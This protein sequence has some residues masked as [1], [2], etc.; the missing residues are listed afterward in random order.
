[1]PES[2]GVPGAL[3]AKSHSA[4][5]VNNA[6]PKKMPSVRSADMRRSESLNFA[7]ERAESVV[8]A[9]L[10]EAVL[11]EHGLLS[12][13]HSRPSA[14]A[15]EFFTKA[16]YSVDNQI[17]FITK[18]L[19]TSEGRDKGFKFM[20]YWCQFLAW[21]TLG[22][23]KLWPGSKD[24]ISK[25][26]EKIR[27]STSTARKFFKLFNFLT[28]IQLAIKICV[29]EKD[30][31]KKGLVFVRFIGLAGYFWFDH[32]NWASKVGIANG[33]PR[34]LAKTG[35]TCLLVSL[36]STF[37]LDYMT[38]SSLQAEERAL[39]LDREAD[40]EI[41]GTLDKTEEAFY[42]DRQKALFT[43]KKAM[44][45]QA[46]KNSLDAF[47]ASDMVFSLKMVPG[48]VALANALSATIGVR[49][50]YKRLV[51]ETKAEQA[52]KKDK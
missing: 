8:S 45:V 7:R 28:F 17:S 38:F 50:Y 1:M 15:A 11:P 36:S 30:I 41:D 44:A 26:F 49:L 3:G 43:K 20:Q 24:V 12:V 37:C 35:L 4:E 14:V 21:Y 27:S 51:K 9:A 16:G 48:Y 23:K 13:D 18:F 19:N 22:S 39:V 34:K 40:M 2:L 31:V 47:A 33:D 6:A 52:K 32:V 5:A 25:R 29:L 46:A 42:H 10:E